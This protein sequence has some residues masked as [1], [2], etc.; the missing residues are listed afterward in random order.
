MPPFPIIPALNI[1]KNSQSC[2][3][4]S[5]EFSGID[6]L[7]FYCFEKTF[8]YSVIPTIGSPAHTLPYWFTF[9][10][11]SE[12]LTG[13][14]HTS[15]GVKQQRLSDGPVSHRHSPGSYTGHLRFHRLTQGPA[16]HLPVSQV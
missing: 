15:I 8:R 4:P 9:K 2:L 5:K 3:L 14:L 6:K 11:L 10:L 1:L 16:H 13:I 7:S 12:L